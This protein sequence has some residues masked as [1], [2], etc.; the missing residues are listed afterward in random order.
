MAAP[1]GAMEMYMGMIANMAEH[2]PEPSKSFLAYFGGM[3]MDPETDK[4]VCKVAGKVVIFH[5]FFKNKT[6]DQFVLLGEGIKGLNWKEGLT[7]DP[8]TGPASEERTFT[9]HVPPNE[10]DAEIKFKFAKKVADK[11]DWQKGQD[12]VVGMKKYGHIAYINL[13][14]DL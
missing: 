10:N 14:V 8:K 1:T 6:Q 12:N 4:R 5:T 2:M 13:E 7:Q 3:N 11:L 9:L